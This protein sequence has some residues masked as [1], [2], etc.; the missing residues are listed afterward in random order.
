M[1]EIG[2]VNAHYS[3]LGARLAAERGIPVVVTLHNSY[4]WFG[5]GAFDEIGSERLER[6]T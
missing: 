2:V 3:T 4:A 1:S 5:P 6:I